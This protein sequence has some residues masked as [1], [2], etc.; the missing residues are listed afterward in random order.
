M[1]PIQPLH[2]EKRRRSIWDT[3][4]L[5]V[6]GFMVIQGLVGGEV[7]PVL[8]GLGVGLFLFFTRHS[9]YELFEDVLVVRFMAPRTI[10]IRLADVQDVRLVK[11]PLGGPALLISRA[12]RG[13]LA[14]MPVDPEGLLARLKAAPGLKT[15]PAKPEA[16]DAPGPA[17]RGRRGPRSR[18]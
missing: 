1:T 18:D 6:A 4:L 11:M 12:G 14:I 2:V 17:Q 8:S 3:L 7:L 10:V 5:F 9:R 16:D 15:Q 13:G